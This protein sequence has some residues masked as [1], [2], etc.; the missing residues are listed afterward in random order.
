VGDSLRVGLG[1]ANANLVREGV[2][3]HRGRDIPR[4]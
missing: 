4:A 3:V 2:A 1:E